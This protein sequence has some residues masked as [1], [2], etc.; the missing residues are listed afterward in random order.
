MNTPFTYDVEGFLNAQKCEN[1]VKRKVS[2]KSETSTQY[3]VSECVRT[4]EG[5]QGG[6]YE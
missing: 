2:E 4:Y 6:N 1:L 5:E 3:A